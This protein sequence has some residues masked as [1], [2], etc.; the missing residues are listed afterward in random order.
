MVFVDITGARRPRTD[1]I[2]NGVWMN[3]GRR[4]RGARGRIKGSINYYT[5]FLVRDCRDSALTPLS[6][7]SACVQELSPGIGSFCRIRSERFR[8]LEFRASRDSIELILNNI[9][10]ISSVI[11]YRNGN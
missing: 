4:G 3:G 8:D 6:E 11:H 1:R 9:K 10:F 7:K 5:R 2:E